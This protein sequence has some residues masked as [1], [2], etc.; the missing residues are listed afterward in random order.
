MTTLYESRWMPDGELVHEWEEKE[1][2]L[3]KHLCALE[4]GWLAEV[5]DLLLVHGHRT[6]R[7]GVERKVMATLGAPYGTPGCVVMGAGFRV[8]GERWEVQCH[9]QGGSVG[10]GYLEVRPVRGSGGADLTWP[11]RLRRPGRPRRPGRRHVARGGENVWLTLHHWIHHACKESLEQVKFSEGEK[12][13]MCY[14]HVCGDSLCIRPAHIAYQ[15]R[16]MD[17]YN[18]KCRTPAEYLGYKKC[19]VTNT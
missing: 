16:K 5:Y 8:K 2:E 14:S 10:A 17:I 6:R 7:G 18:R 19:K 13:V 3:H 11:L 1:G 12:E 9:K 4:P 15:T